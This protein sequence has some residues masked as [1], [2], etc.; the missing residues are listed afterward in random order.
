MYLLPIYYI[1]KI[2][3]EGLLSLVPIYILYEE[4][5]DDLSLYRNSFYK[6]IWI[7]MTHF[8]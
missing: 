7:K 8:L 1:K 6:K 4:K 3:Y 5:K 2:K